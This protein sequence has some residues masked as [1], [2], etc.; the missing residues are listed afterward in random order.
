[1]LRLPNNPFKKITGSHLVIS[2]LSLM[3]ITACSFSASPGSG[4]QPDRGVQASDSGS[5][6]FDFD[7]SKLLLTPLSSPTPQLSQ[8]NRTDITGSSSSSDS[9]S[10]TDEPELAV[11]LTP[12]L[13]PTASPEPQPEPSVTS[14]VPREPESL[15]STPLP[16]LIPTVE[17]TPQSTSTPMV[18]GVDVKPKVLPCS[19]SSALDLYLEFPDGD[20]PAISG[21]VTTIYLCLSQIRHGLAGFDISIE[22]PNGDVA[23][24]V[25]AQIP[26]FGLKQVVGI[27][28]SQ[29][30]RLRAVDLNGKVPYVSDGALLASI[31]VR[32]KSPGESLIKLT[33]KALDDNDGNAIE[34]IITQTSLVVTSS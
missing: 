33:V 14:T 6:A 7:A 19:S 30:V 29:T 21:E 18:S 1:M 34:A 22:L 24:I 31:D 12:T 20:T 2:L 4:D 26:N 23:E 27:L 5:D 17:P 9:S 15:P 13:V 28:P 10:E 11:A 3:A 32:A 25:K 16:T 8:P